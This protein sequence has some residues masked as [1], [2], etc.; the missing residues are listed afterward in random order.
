MWNDISLLAGVFKA[1]ALS[2][3]GPCVIPLLPPLAA[4]VAGYALAS[5]TTDERGLA[6]RRWRRAI[7]GAVLII[8]GFT[9]MFVL[10]SAP[11]LAIQPRLAASRSTL[12]LVA[13]ALIAVSGAELLLRAMERLFGWSG[14]VLDPYRRLA[15]PLAPLIGAALY[16]GWTTC[17][18]PVLG[19]VLSLSSSPSTLAAGLWLLAVYAGGLA[20][21]LLLFAGIIAFVAAQVSRPRMVVALIEIFLALGLIATGVLIPRGGMQSAGN[22]LIEN[23]PALT[24][25]EEATTAPDLPLAI[26]KKA[27]P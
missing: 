16:F 17:V 27:V 11:A 2:A 14:E 5:V 24:R 12:A 9:A 7:L 25:I 10:L 26:M 20:V 3:V 6:G 13:G 18:G 1:G 21:A 19:P 15:M 8:L 4:L 23:Y 22:W